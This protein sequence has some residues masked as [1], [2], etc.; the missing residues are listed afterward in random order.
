MIC[1]STVTAMTH[2]ATLESGR[3]LV[4]PTGQQ[5]QEDRR[6]GQR[7]DHGQQFVG[8]DRTPRGGEAA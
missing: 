5:Q 3:E 1:S 2:A 6:R 4:A 8:G 7:A